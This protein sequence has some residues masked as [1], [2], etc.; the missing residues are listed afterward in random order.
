MCLRNVTWQFCKASFCFGSFVFGGPKKKKKGGGTRDFFLPTRGFCPKDSQCSKSGGLQYYWVTSTDK[1][2][3]NSASSKNL[4]P[5]TSYSYGHVHTPAEVKTVFINSSCSVNN[6]FMLLTLME[7]S[8]TLIT[9]PPASSSQ[10]PQNSASLANS[11]FKPEYQQNRI[12]K[13]VILNTGK[14]K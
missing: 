13:V 6:S 10:G 8:D 5:E 7:A 11:R 14:V 9:T 2:H 4:F 12:L 3:F 1:R